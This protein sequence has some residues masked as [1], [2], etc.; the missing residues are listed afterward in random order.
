MY[1]T[2]MYSTARRHR[3]PYRSVL[4]PI[5]DD[6]LLQ[7]V[8]RPVRNFMALYVHMGF[9]VVHACMNKFSAVLYKALAANDTKYRGRP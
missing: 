7:L 3:F 8:H 5:Q 1:C 9:K 4:F 2:Y 6:Q